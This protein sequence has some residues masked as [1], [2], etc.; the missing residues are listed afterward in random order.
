ME[1]RQQLSG[2]LYLAIVEGTERQLAVR[3]GTKVGDILRCE[4]RGASRYFLA[5]VRSI[6]LGIATIAITH[7]HEGLRN[8]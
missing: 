7:V 4:L 5:R 3:D 2:E 6:D 1:K 8:G